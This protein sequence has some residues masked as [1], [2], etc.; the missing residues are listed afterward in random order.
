VWDAT[1]PLRADDL[2]QVR[3]HPYYT[4][5][6][7]TRSPF[8]RSLNDVASAHHERLDGSGYHRGTGGSGL[9]VP[10]RILAAA[11]TYRTKVETRPHR[12]ALAPD[13]AAAHLRGE[14]EAGRLDVAAVDA[15]L[16]A[17]GQVTDRAR[18]RLTPREIEILTVAARGGSMRQ[19]ARKLG[20]SPKTVDGHLQRIYPK[21]GV[22]TRGGATLYAIE[23]GLLAHPSGA[24][25]GENSP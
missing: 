15:V 19:I 7:L 5:Q 20:I 10:A 2:E 3:L 18:P 16:L 22:Q 6:V 13:A 24:A 12:P 23:H 14:A 11:D 21:I 17:A 1:E 4:D 25:T 9:D 8:L